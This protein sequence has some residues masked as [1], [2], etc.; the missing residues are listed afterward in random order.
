MQRAKTARRR[1]TLSLGDYDR[2]NLARPKSAYKQFCSDTFKSS[3]VFIPKAELKLQWEGLDEAKKLQLIENQAAKRTN[4][5]A[6]IQEL[7]KE[8]ALKEAMTLTS[9][10]VELLKVQLEI[11]PKQESPKKKP[12]QESPKRKPYSG[13]KIFRSQQLAALRDQ[14]PSLTWRERLNE[15]RKAWSALSADEKTKLVELARGN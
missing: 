14:N 8:K 15:V 4:F 5:N 6:L 3:K 11:K 9:S 10:R 12:K 2:P 13:F 7:R 1:F